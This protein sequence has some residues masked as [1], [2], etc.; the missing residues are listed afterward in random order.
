[1]APSPLK[2]QNRLKSSKNLL[3]DDALVNMHNHDHECKCLKP[4]D[5]HRF[6]Q[7]YGFRRKWHIPLFNFTY[8]E[9]T[10]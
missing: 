3:Q 9:H 5:S 8:M 7:I 6:K 4:Q 10:F 1:M 2:F